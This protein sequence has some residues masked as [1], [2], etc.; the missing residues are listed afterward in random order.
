MCT[1][2]HI[3]YKHTYIQYLD[4]SP[5]CSVYIFVFRSDVDS[6]VVHVY[7][8]HRLM[9]SAYDSNVVHVYRLHRLI[10]SVYIRGDKLLSA[11]CHACNMLF[12]MRD[13][14]IYIFVMWYTHRKNALGRTCPP[15]R[16]HIMCGVCLC[17]GL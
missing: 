16:W 5:S 1:K 12:I 7:R 3:D 17:V 13:S 15:Y 8:L 4:C 2:A 11:A 9:Y 10:Y 14:H 6:N